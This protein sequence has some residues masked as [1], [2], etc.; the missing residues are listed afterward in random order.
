[1][2]RIAQKL[3]TVL[4]RRLPEKRLFLRTET[5]TRFVRLSPT[6]QLVAWVGS[7]GVIAWAIVATAI[8][9][10]DSIG[11]GNFREQ[12]KREQVVYQERLNSLA[13]QRDL[14]A[15]EATAAQARFNSALEQIS[16]MQSK[17]LTSEEQRRE[18]ERGV[19]AMQVKLA[20]ALQD[21]RNLQNE[22]SELLASL[23]AN[24]GGTAQAARADEV[25]S[26]LAFLNNALGDTAAE[27]DTTAHNAQVALNFANEMEGELRLLEARND[28]IFR[29]LEEAMN[30][31]VQPLDRMFRRA[32]LNTDS[33]IT[34]VRRGYSGQGG[35]LTALSISTKNGGIAPD[36]ARANNILKDLDEM[37]LYRI[38]AQLTPFVMP[39]NPSQVRKTSNYGP[40]WGRMH[41][42]TDWAGP[43]GTDIKA[44]ADGVVVHAGWSSG[45]GRLIKIQHEFG[46]ETRY[47]HLSKIR[48]RVGQRVSR[49][50]HIGDLGNSG[51]ST[52]PHLHYEIRVGGRPVDPMIYIKAAQ[53]VL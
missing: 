14:R 27:R 38:A 40:R 10:M 20:A 48:V 53:D 8:L 9:L 6:T 21:Q 5:E 1:M 16:D 43:V 41:Y 37:N 36:A 11:A 35:P 28:Q 13:G 51:R 44:T 46:I 52:G 33:L 15:A 45:Y 47:A 31:S 7:V 26:I 49:G 22:H 34:Q 23:D 19:D 50:Q 4:D 42:G 39:V 2:S 17:L 32:G 18:L 25:E 3:N 30:V 29:R 24:D 12:A